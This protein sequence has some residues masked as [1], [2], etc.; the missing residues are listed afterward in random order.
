MAVM[1]PIAR[2]LTLRKTLI[3]IA[4]IWTFAALLSLPA[5][6]FT[7]TLRYEYAEGQTRTMCVLQWPDGLPG[8]SLYDYV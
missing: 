1:H 8:E 5:I 4:V 2:R 6:L 3:C 7:T